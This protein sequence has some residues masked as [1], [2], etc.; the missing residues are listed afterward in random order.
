MS[1]NLFSKLRWNPAYDRFMRF[2]YV[3]K[4]I[5]INSIGWKNIHCIFFLSLYLYFFLSHQ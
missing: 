1:G 2:F 3:F 4:Y 5:G